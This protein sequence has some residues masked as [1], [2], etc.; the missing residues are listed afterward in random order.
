MAKPRLRFKEFTDDWEQRKLSECASF[1]RGSFPQ[2]YGKK[3]WYGG[4]DAKPFVQVVD[5]DQN[6]KLVEKT[7][8]SISVVAQP[9]SVFVKKGS[10]VVTLQ[11]SIGR[12]AVTQYDAYFDRT[13]LILRTITK[14]QIKGF[15]HTLYKIN[16][17][18]KKK[19]PLVEQ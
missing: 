8:Q 10:V 13:I 1:R 7:K 18:S 11:G 6:L 3:E 2:P 14:G 4:K 5:I 19:K 9:M 12:V 17:T 16:L 15:G